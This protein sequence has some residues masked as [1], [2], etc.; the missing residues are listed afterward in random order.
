MSAKTWTAAQLTE[1]TDGEE[2]VLVLT[3]PD[4]PVL[5]VPVWVVTAHGVAYV[6]SYLGVKSGWYRRVMT[7]Q[8]QAIVL[9]GVDLP[10]DFEL[11]PVTEPVNADINDAFLAKYR[12]DPYAGY[13]VLPLALEATLRILPA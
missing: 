11:V 1:L 10:V 8:H 12:A 13:M 6:R 4:R 2:L 5:R 9:G 3:H 7:Q